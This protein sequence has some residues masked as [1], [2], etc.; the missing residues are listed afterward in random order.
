MRIFY[1]QDLASGIDRLSPL[2]KERLVLYGQ[3]LWAEVD[4]VTSFADKDHPISNQNYLN[5]GFEQRGY[6]NMLIWG[7]L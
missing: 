2:L 5:L 1:A 3:L 6:S 7:E 4:T